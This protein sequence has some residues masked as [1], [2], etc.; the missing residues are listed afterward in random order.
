VAFP[1]GVSQRE[2]ACEMGKLAQGDAIDEIRTAA[3]DRILDL[4]HILSV[5]RNL[6]QQCG[7]RMESEVV[8]VRHP[9]A[10]GVDQLQGGLEPARNRV[11]QVGDE[12]PSAGRDDQLLSLIGQLRFGIDSHQFIDAAQEVARVYRP[13][14]D[15]FSFSIGGTNNVPSLETAPGHKRGEDLAVMVAA[16]VPGRAL[17]DLGGAAELAAAPDDRAVQQAVFRQVGKE[18]REARVQVRQ[19][20]A[21]GSEVVGVRIPAA[22]V[23]SDVG[24]AALDQTPCRQTALAASLGYFTL[25]LRKQNLLELSS[26]SLQRLERGRG[27][28]YLS[29]SRTASTG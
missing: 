11:G 19:Q 20:L 27:I 23:D 25:S 7:I 12:F 28:A 21:H 10:L 8:L 6:E 14:L 9:S 29:D 4:H 1:A 13:V 26:A 17:V 3:V 2:N 5:L 18:R 22:E 15:F 24:H 16:A